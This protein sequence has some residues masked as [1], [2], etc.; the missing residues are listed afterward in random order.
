MYSN[1][2]EEKPEI[3]K[4]SHSHDKTHI[5]ARYQDQVPVIDLGERLEIKKQ[6][7]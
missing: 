1:Q 6:N 3:R 5:Y 4:L 2:I 7:Y